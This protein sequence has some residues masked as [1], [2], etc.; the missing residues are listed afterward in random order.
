MYV[1]DDSRW[2]AVRDRDPKADQAFVYCVRTTKIYCRP[3]C[4]ARL[5]RRSNVIFYS[6]PL[7]AQNAGYRACKRCKP[8]I[9][10]SM[11]EEDAVRKIMDFVAHPPQNMA[12]S[13]LDTMAKQTGLSK[14]HFHRVFKKVVG[15]TPSQYAN[16]FR[17]ESS[18]TSQYSQNSSAIFDLSSSSTA[19]TSPLHVENPESVITWDFLDFLTAD[20][21]EPDFLDVSSML[22]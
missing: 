13:N 11:P 9:A 12:L 6:T 22:T 14:W 4:K 18:T 8:E 21:P 16:T 2:S 10:S 5:A 19:A 20:S 3:I 17:T 15:M 7:E 1:N